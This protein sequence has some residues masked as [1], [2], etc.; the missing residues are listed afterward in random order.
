MAFAVID[1]G[2]DFALLWVTAMDERGEFWCV[3]NPQMRLQANLSM[4]GG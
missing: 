4:A 2:P 1:Y 3:P